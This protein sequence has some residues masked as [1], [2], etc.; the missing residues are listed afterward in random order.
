METFDFSRTE[1]AEAPSQNLFQGVMEQQPTESTKA[2]FASMSSTKVQDYGFPTL[3]LTDSGNPKSFLQ[4][5]ATDSFQSTASENFQ[6]KYS[7]FGQARSSERTGPQTRHE[8]ENPGDPRTSRTTGRNSPFEQQ[9]PQ[10]PRVRPDAHPAQKP[11][12]AHPAHKPDSQQR[13][14]ERNEKPHQKPSDKAGPGEKEVSV[15]PGET[16]W[17]IAKKSLQQNGETPS[18]RDIL[19]MV[20]EIA[21]RN[22]IKDSNKI[23]PGQHFII[24]KHKH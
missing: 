15:K 1:R 2:T 7:P 6:Q 12:D 8:G 5:S 9:K 22:G 21:R 14:A 19:K 10:E 13:P 11:A 20:D 16:L 3:Q 24:P 17:G 4:A 23:H 18:P